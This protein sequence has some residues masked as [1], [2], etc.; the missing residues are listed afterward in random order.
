MIFFFVSLN[1]S[2]SLL[3][4]TQIRKNNYISICDDCDRIFEETTV[5]INL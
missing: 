1:Y 4:F 5:Y 3:Y 2:K